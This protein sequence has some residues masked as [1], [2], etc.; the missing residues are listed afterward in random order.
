MARVL[1]HDAARAALGQPCGPAT[2]LHGFALCLALRDLVEV[3]RA[4]GWFLTELTAWLRPDPLWA[5]LAPLRELAVF[6]AACD[7][8]EDDR[9][10][11]EA[12]RL[13]GKRRTAPHTQYSTEYL[14]PYPK[15]N[16]LR[17]LGMKPGVDSQIEQSAVVSA[18]F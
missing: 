7:R 2:L 9:E 3:R 18:D 1:A 4:S 5:Q 16:T 14:L 8:A 6:V 17:E 13:F 10:L 15:C 11:V 12:A